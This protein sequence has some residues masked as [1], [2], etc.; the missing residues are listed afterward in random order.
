MGAHTLLESYHEERHPVGV[1]NT[2]L[3]RRFADHIGHFRPPQFLE[4]PGTEGQQARLDAGAFLLDHMQQEFN[5]PGI[6]FGV[7]YD[8]SPIVASDGSHAPPDEIN[9]YIPTACP[10]GRAPHR[11]LP[12]GRS[13]YDCFG[14]EFTL[15]VMGKDFSAEPMRQHAAVAG[16]PLSILHLP[17]RELRNLYEADLA[18]IRPDQHVAWRGNKP[19]EAAKALLRAAG[20][21]EE[22]RHN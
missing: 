15:L 19:G 20:W 4:D 7:R 11:W 1:R 9:R 3:A 22:R 14:P 21:P 12:D 2:G 8:G 10:G 16:I 17:D 6:T 5:I 18:L 13:L